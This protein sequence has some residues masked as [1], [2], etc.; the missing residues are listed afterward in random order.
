LGV[1]KGAVS[2]WVARGKAGGVAALC[3]QPCDF[4]RNRRIEKAWA[5][6]F[7]TK[8]ISVAVARQPNELSVEKSSARVE[9]VHVSSISVEKVHESVGAQIVG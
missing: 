5:F 2:Q 7:A 1:S 9:K 4:Q 3:N 6:G 8:Y